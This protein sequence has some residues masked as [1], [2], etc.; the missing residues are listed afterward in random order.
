MWKDFFEYFFELTLIIILIILGVGLAMAG[1]FAI[2]LVIAIIASGFAT[3]AIWAWAVFAV[4]VFVI[5]VSFIFA[6]QDNH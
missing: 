4:V 2:G 6:W 5:I 3:P 1:L